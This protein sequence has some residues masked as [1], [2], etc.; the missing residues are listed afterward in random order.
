MKN[1]RTFYTKYGCF[2]LTNFQ[3]VVWY[4]RKDMELFATV[5]LQRICSAAIDSCSFHCTEKKEKM[6]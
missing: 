5:T 1:S 6:L 2:C 4:N 3:I